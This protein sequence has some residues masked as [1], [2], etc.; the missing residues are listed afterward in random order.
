MATLL[1]PS[2]IFGPVHSRRLGLSLG[3]NLLPA[4]GKVCTFDCIYCECGLNAQRRTS[5]KMPE[6]SSVIQQLQTTLEKMTQQGEL[7]DVLTFAG[8]GEPTA[9]PQFAEIVDQTLRLRDEYAPAAKI[10][11]LTNGTQIHKPHV[12]NALMKV[13]DNIVK[14]DTVNQAYIDR[15]DRPCGY[16][17]VQEQV[18]WMQRFNGHIMIQTLFMQG[19]DNHGVSVDNTDEAFI[20]PWLD[21]LR[22]IAP[23]KVMVYT[24]DRETPMPGLEKARPEVLEQIAQRVKA[25]GIAVSVSY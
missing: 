20:Q 14:L 19:H 15:V 2:P 12:F 18:Q 10:A 3:I 7:P 9:H 1:H 11:V 25:L 5:Q 6:A 17:R 21:A 24:I 13:D 22:L 23:E 8:N 4:T 16:Y